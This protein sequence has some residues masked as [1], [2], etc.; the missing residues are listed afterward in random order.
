MKIWDGD[1]GESIERI[2]DFTTTA[3]INEA[4]S[5]PIR[6]SSCEVNPTYR[7]NPE[8]LNSPVHSE[9][10]TLIR[11]CTVGLSASA[12]MVISRRQVKA[13][14][15]ADSHE[16]KKK[17]PTKIK[18]EYAIDLLRDRNDCVSRIS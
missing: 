8:H 9:Q 1:E 6:Q 7:P 13:E 12:S 18:K 3:A 10:H 11:R 2:G 14:G 17:N 4:T 15:Q 16:V 5:W